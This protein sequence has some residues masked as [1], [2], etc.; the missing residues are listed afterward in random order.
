MFEATVCFF[1]RNGATG[2]EVLLSRKL[3]GFG[4][5]NRNGYSGHIETKET[6]EETTIR[7][8]GE[9]CG[10]EISEDDLDLLGRILIYRGPRESVDLYVY[11]CW[12]SNRDFGDSSEMADPQWF[13][14]DQLP[15]SEMNEGDELW[16]HYVLQGIQ[17]GTCVLYKTRDG[18]LVFVSPTLGI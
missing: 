17:F 9:E 16:I 18:E 8:I 4:T 3:T 6:P 15:I 12:D 2:P 10:V 14:E 5:G 7:E 11:I 13:S 1:M